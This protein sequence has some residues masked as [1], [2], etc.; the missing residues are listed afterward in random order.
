[1]EL[2]IAITGIVLAESAPPPLPAPRLVFVSLLSRASQVPNEVLKFIVLY[3][4][5]CG[6]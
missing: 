6:Y 5:A 2:N 1:M 3:V 4:F